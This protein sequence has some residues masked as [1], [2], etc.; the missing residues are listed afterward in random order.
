M[1]ITGAPVI[2]YDAVAL[3]ERQSVKAGQSLILT[4]NILGAP[5]PTSSWNFKDAELKTKSGVSIEGDGTFSRITI[6]NTSALN[7][8]L[9]TITAKNDSGVASVDFD[10]VVQGL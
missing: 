9:Y 2:E 10:C 7:S 8:G 4:V 6:K 1:R 3:K 5:T